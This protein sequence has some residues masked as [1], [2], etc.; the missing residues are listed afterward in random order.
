MLV[1]GLVFQ[2]HAP[3]MGLALGQ[4]MPSKT[5]VL[6]VTAMSIRV[7]VTSLLFAAMVSSKLVKAAIKVRAMEHVRL[8]VAGA[9]LPIAVLYVAME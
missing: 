6:G 9:A 4:S 2:L 1:H 3:T 5:V 7:V 8:P